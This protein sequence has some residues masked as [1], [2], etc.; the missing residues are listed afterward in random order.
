[1]SDEIAHSNHSQSLKILVVD[2]NFINHA[3]LTSILQE[4]G[5]EV[6]TANDGSAAIEAIKKNFF[7]LILMDIQMPEM[8]GKVATRKIR[9]I[10]GPKSEIP[11]VA[12]TADSSEKHMEEYQEIGMNSLL[13]K[14]IDKTE[15]LIILDDFLNGS[16]HFSKD[17]FKSHPPQEPQE[18]VAALDDLLKQ[19]GG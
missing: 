15:L 8:D 5:H 19:I 10:P 6:V 18:P 12:C 3:I 13:S 16:L 11:I 1:M 4:Q 9:K 2:D 7:D 17:I 14:P